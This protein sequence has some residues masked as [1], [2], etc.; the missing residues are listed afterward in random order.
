MIGLII[1]I[2]LFN[3]I[4]FKTNK[5]LTANQIVHIWTATIAFQSIFDLMVEF[6]Y[7][8]YWYF[9]KGVEWVDILPHTFLI[10]PV[11]MMFINWYPFRAKITKQISY[12]FFWVIAILIYETVTLFPEPWGYFHYG[13]WNLRHATVIDPLLFIILLKYY[14]WICKLE[15]KACGKVL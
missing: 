12:I 9:D 11:N 1:S 4:A 3:L 8:G 5:R 2:V 14:L 7:K 6:K 15:N 13:W 10:P